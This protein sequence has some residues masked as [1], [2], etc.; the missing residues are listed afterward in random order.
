MTGQDINVA[1][2]PPRGAQIRKK[3]RERMIAARAARIA[4]RRHNQET[5][6]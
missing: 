4:Y 3:R 2:E 5:R 6:T 1:A